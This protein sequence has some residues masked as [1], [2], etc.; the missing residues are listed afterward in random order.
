MLTKREFI[1][2]PII[3]QPQTKLEA[4]MK[5]NSRIRFNPTTKEVEI[6]GSEKFIKTYFNK[7]QELMSGIPTVV[8]R[9]KR[10]REEETLPLRVVKRV[11][12]GKVATEGKRTM[13]DRVVGL[14]YRSKGITTGELKEKTGL[15]EK[16]IWSITY[17]AEKLGRIKRGKRG[18]Y[19]PVAA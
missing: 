9:A 12:R 17:R 3:K 2:Y 14:I 11:R 16:Q 7:I 19:E 6:E 10:I 1:I 18:V 5:E 15:T 4:Y 13:F 8:T